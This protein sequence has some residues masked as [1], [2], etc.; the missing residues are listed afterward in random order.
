ML[1]TMVDT[2]DEWIIQRTGISERHL[3]GDLTI[4]DMAESA[5]RQALRQAGSD[6]ADLVICATSTPDFLFPSLACRLGARLGI[7]SAVCL[8]ISAACTGFIQAMDIADRYIRTGAARTALVIAAEK[9]SDII[10]YGDRTT[11]IL[12]GDAAA[13]VFLSVGEGEHI[14][15]SFISSRNDGWEFLTGRVG[16]N[17]SMAGQDVYKFAVWAMPEAIERVLERSGKTIDDVRW[18]IPHQANI[19][20]IRSVMQKF[21]LP[22]EKVMI[23][24][25]KTGNTSSA[26]IPCILDQMS[27]EG[28]LQEGD[29]VLMVAF[30]AGLTY[31][32]MLY[33][34]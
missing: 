32:A 28:K 22:Q 24:L 27:R 3:A 9:L 29:L 1:E 15:G 30:G 12:F 18:I 23:T 26:T 7:A 19:R 31:G 33:E 14:K 4:C 11:C 13:A 16:S 21:N 25:D 5:A 34:W 10:D 6:N 20:I 8:D 2:S 17:L